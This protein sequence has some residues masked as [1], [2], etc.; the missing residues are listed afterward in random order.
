MKWWPRSIR[1]RW[2]QLEHEA[3]QA[4]HR[5]AEAK[6]QHTKAS[7]I[8]AERERIRRVNGFTEAIRAAMGVSGAPQQDPRHG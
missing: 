3:D 7:S 5:L 1:A 2:E 6:A 8:A 4:E